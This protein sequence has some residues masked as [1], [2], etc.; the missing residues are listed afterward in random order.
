MAFCLLPSIA[1]KFLEKVKAGE[2]NPEKLMGMTSK[3]R[4]EYFS[5]FMPEEAAK[6]VNALFESKILLKHQQEGIISW[7]KQITGIKPDVRAG[8]L[9]RVQNMKEYL[10]PKQLDAFLNDLVAQKLGVEVTVEEA[11]KITELAQVVAQ[12]KSLMDPKTFKFPTKEARME[13]GVAQY[14]FGQYV[15]DLKATNKSLLDIIKSPKAIVHELAGTA[16]SMQSSYDNSALLRPGFFV[17]VNEPIIWVKNAANSFKDI[18]DTFKGKDVEMMIKADINSRVNALNGTYKKTKLALP[19]TEESFPES[20]VMGVIGKLPVLGKFYK[21]TEVA[22]NGFAARNRADIMDKHIAIIKQTDAEFSHP[23][24][25][26]SYVNSL[27]GRGRLGKLEPIADV[28]NLTFYSLRRQAANFDILTGNA[29][30]WTTS[31]PYTR[32]VAAKSTLKTILG[33]GAILA[34]AKMLNPDGVELD[35]RSSD[36]GYVKAMGRKFD[37]T[38]GLRTMVVLGA[39]MAKRSIKT[40]SGIQPLNEGGFMGKNVGSLI[41]DFFTNKLSPVASVLNDVYLRG[42]DYSGEKPTVLGELKK[43]FTPFILQTGQEISNN[44][45][46]A[47]YVAGLLLLEAAGLGSQDGTFK[48]KVPTFDEGNSDEK[49]VITE[50]QR[51]ANAGFKPGIVDIE[52]PTS[53]LLKMKEQLTPEKFDELKTY[54]HDNLS[55]K[56]LDE[57]SSNGYQSASVDTKKKRIEHVQT[58][59]VNETLGK[60][61]YKKTPPKH[62]EDVAPKQ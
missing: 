6:S 43:T 21:A 60:F 33:I 59:V 4:R 55:R 46:A 36:F 28:V 19:S 34:I 47:P 23:E 61:G 49:K 56:I 14:A 1:E 62:T 38:F 13:Y 45:D 58:G 35:P 7:A 25:L 40:K 39:R 20:K 51:L 24:A 5:T 48:T 52:K 32:K 27:T 37:V 12:K 16:K 10:K 11:G 22:F 30:D 3:G 31:D 15:S 54:L 9:E 41:S 29:R 50:I 42:T 53:N 26:G 57:I 44:P 17:A 18:W 2:I 8:L